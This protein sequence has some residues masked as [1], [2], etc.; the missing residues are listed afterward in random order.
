M[1]PALW[2]LSEDT[3]DAIIPHP[4]VSHWV[5]ALDC[6]SLKSRLYIVSRHCS[7]LSLL[8]PS[9]Q[10]RIG[11][12]QTT[13]QRRRRRIGN[14]LLHYCLTRARSHTT[15][16]TTSHLAHRKPK[17]TIPS[18]KSRQDKRNQDLR[19]IKKTHSRKKNNKTG[20]TKK[21]EETRNK[22]GY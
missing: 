17:N 19:K 22:T 5:T 8:P 9:S 3:A 4:S 18:C 7:N 2:R 11:C 12:L 13:I 16:V 1:N 6:C 21:K 10:G 20:S 14:S 15:P